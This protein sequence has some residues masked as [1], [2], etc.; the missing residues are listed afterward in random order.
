MWCLCHVAWLCK[1][2]L[3]TGIARACLAQSSGG[4]AVLSPD[5]Y[6]HV[7]CIFTNLHKKLWTQYPLIFPA[8]GFKTSVIGLLFQHCWLLAW[9]SSVVNGDSG[10]NALRGGNHNS[11]TSELYWRLAKT[12]PD[13]WRAFAIL[14][15]DYEMRWLVGT[16]RMAMCCT[17]LYGWHCWIKIGVSGLKGAL[18]NEQPLQQVYQFEVA[19]LTVPSI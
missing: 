7:A 11:T 18:N 8:Y 12:T 6:T 17:T 19:N 1:L 13:V 9:M 3:L 2:E 14:Q 4:D 16:Q 5:A 10:M 15:A